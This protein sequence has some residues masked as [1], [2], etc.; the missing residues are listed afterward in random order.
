M[1]EFV[2]RNDDLTAVST[3]TDASLQPDDNFDASCEQLWAKLHELEHVAN[4]LTD[5]IK[6]T[7][8]LDTEMF[9]DV[10]G[11]MTDN[12]TTALLVDIPELAGGQSLYLS[13]ICIAPYGD[14]NDFLVDQ[15][16][17]PDH[18]DHGK[19]HISLENNDNPLIRFTA[20][21]FRS[22][23]SLLLDSRHEDVVPGRYT[24]TV[25]N[26]GPRM[27]S[28]R[29]SL[30]VIERVKAMPVRAGET[31]RHS[32]RSGEFSYFRFENHDPSKLVTIR[33]TPAYDDDGP[34]GDPDLYVS[35]RCHGYTAVTKDTFV[36]KSTNV[37]A[38][39]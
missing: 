25:A 4:K 17:R 3:I 34:I 13:A 22:E 32:N 16:P 7:L 15:G 20:Q 36:W 2:H 8:Q 35:N 10:G 39:R 5:S 14:E 9:V 33:A 29:V 21:Y 38:D 26:Q 31:I 19:M 11:K 24:I 18:E 6:L 23:Y 12:H 27:V 1:A 28:L 30:R 37:G